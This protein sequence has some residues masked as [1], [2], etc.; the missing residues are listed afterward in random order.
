LL[1]AQNV[2]GTTKAQC[3]V[4]LDGLRK[5]RAAL[6][7]LKDETKNQDVASH[8][9]PFLT[10][11]VEV[12]QEQ[13]ANAQKGLI[14][15]LETETSLR[16]KYFNQVQELKGNIRVYCRVRPCSAKEREAHQRSGSDLPVEC[17]TFQ[18][19]ALTLKQDQKVNKVFEFEQVFKPES[20][21]D[22]VFTEVSDLV[23]S[24]LDGYNTCIFAYGQTGSGKTYTMNGPPENPGVNTRA[25]RKLFEEVDKRADSSE[26]EVVMTLVEI[27]CEKIQ[28]LLSL[29]ANGDLQ[30]SLGP[31]GNSEI[32]NVTYCAV[33]SLQEVLDLLARG[34]GNRRVRMTEMNSQSSRSHL[35]LSITC[36]GHNRLLN[37]STSAKLHLIDLA[38]SE[39]I[40]RSGVEG[41]ALEESISI[42]SSLHALGNCIE[43][44]AQK[45]GHVSYRDSKLTLLLKDSLEGNSKT[46]MFVN[47][48][49]LT[50][51]ASE[52]NSSLMFATKVRQ[53]EIGKASANVAKD[54]KDRGSRAGSVVAAN[55]SGKFAK[56]AKSSLG[57]LGTL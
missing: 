51:D 43:Q 40:N 27:Y 57:K 10:K 48:S 17:M 12:L 49:P 20:T 29:Q 21:Q 13:F 46:L 2:M 16:R 50:A 35:V 39:R 36:N 15:K 14:K 37:K 34:Q 41:D 33:S 54:L 47:L 11:K 7:Q 23:L 18:E 19:G 42:N 31:N 25:L 45:R 6:R 26:F 55:S 3:Q 4:L 22:Q 9:R 32:K 5:T 52:T 1:R 30:V 24:V 38:G 8:I 44:R 28:D 53:V 56:V